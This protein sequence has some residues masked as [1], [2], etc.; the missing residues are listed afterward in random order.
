M[1]P[2]IALELLLHF[3]IP[4]HILAYKFIAFDGEWKVYLNSM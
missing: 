3:Y 2:I 4:W 1:I